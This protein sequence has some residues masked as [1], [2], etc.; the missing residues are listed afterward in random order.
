MYVLPVVRLLNP[1]FTPVCGTL[2]REIV[3]HTSLL[4]ALYFD[5]GVSVH[6]VDDR[7]PDPAFTRK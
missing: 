7:T 3:T 4:P 6:D 2:Q 1:N 5:L